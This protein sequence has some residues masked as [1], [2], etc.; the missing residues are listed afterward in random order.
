[1]KPR[2]LSGNLFIHMETKKTL[3]ELVNAHVNTKLEYYTTYKSIVYNIPL[4]S[5]QHTR[6]HIIQDTTP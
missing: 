4:H 5:I 2:R 3:K 6:L 1:M